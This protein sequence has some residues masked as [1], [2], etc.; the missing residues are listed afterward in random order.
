[1]GKNARNIRKAKNRRKLLGIILITGIVFFLLGFGFSYF[2]GN[3]NKGNNYT[4]NINKT[5]DA[6]ESKNI[7]EKE[8][9]TKNGAEGTNDAANDSQD[10]EDVKPS[11]SVTVKEPDSL[12]PSNP[13]A[14]NVQKLD[15]KVLEQ[16]DNK[17]L[18]WWYRPNTNNKPSTIPDDI[19]ELIGKYDGIFQGDTSKKVVYLTFDEGYE[20]GYTPMILDALKE[21]DVKAIFFVTGSY[22]DRNPDLVKR[23]LDEGHQVGSHT[24]N[25]P[26]L[27]DLGYEELENELL[28]LEEKFYEKFNAGFRYMR[29]P[30]GEYSERTLAATQQLGY[31]TVFWSFAYD[32]WYTDK[33]RGA[34]YAYNKVMEN[35]HNGAVL[36]LHAV[37]KDNAEAMD[38]IIKDIK[39]K[40]YEIRPFDL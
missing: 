37:S 5:G 3:F 30:M 2:I 24:V 11:P 19:S 31:K 12:S 20:N 35:L 29:P 23:M 39:A 36:L 14:P 40:G 13:T 10:D 22:I 25:H 17:K 28:G 9:E 26:S 6:E 15:V 8:E 34:D 33:I 38:R 7:D 18:S 4:G 16:L 32:D 27:P 1:M 21:N